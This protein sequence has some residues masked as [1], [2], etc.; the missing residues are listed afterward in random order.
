MLPLFLITNG[1]HEIPHARVLFKISEQFQQKKTGGIAGEAGEAVLMS[2]DGPYKRKIDK[3]GDKPGK[4]TRD[5]ATRI[6]LDMARSV[7]MG[8][9]SVS[10]S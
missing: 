9:Q 7:G 2:N 3:E 10:G 5:P 8:Q 4:P 1:F 6:N